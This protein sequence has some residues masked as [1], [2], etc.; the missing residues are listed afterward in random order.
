MILTPGDLD[1]LARTI[2]GEAR[3]ESHEGR[4]AVAHVIFNRVR[5]ITGQFARDDTIASACLRHL[6]FS[7][8]NADDPNLL[9]MQRAGLENITFRA[10]MRAALEA[11]DAPDQTKGARHYHATTVKP[12]WAT[13]HKPSA[14]IGWHLFYN[15]ID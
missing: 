10:C 15:D 8:W 7:C 1:I 5:T 13:G 14:I 2:F 4:K 6:Q 9:V 12:S 11:F 3:G